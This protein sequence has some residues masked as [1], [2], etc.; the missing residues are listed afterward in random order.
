MNE[1]T[2]DFWQ[3]AHRFKAL[4]CTCNTVV[5]ADGSLVMGRGI[6]K[7]FA[8]RY[9]ELAK[10]WGPRVRHGYAVFTNLTRYPPQTG[11]F[12]DLNAKLV[13]LVY[14][15]TKYNWRDRST[16]GIVRDSLGQLID[17]IAMLNLKSVLL[18]RPGCENGGLDWADVKERIERDFEGELFDRITF[19]G[20]PQ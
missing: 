1:I 20:R 11:L 13:H 4:C 6:A 5:K 15:R 16:W 12:E 10:E 14:F 18:P 9:P 19:I 3:E 8:E 7:Q 2:G 17:L